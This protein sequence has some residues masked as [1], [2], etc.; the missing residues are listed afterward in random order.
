M[1]KLLTFF[2]VK[3]VDNRLK[4]REFNIS[5]KLLEKMLKKQWILS[6]TCSSGYHELGLKSVTLIRLLNQELCGWSYR[7]YN[8]SSSVE[9]VLEGFNKILWRKFWCKI[10]VFCI[11]FVR[12]K[13]WTSGR[14]SIFFSARTMLIVRRLWF[15]AMLLYVILERMGIDCAMLWSYNYKHA[16]SE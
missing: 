6:K 4:K 11:T 8:N 12:Y 7:G 16:M 10:S 3:L 13:V 15:K 9:S 2:L 1:K 14:T 5:F